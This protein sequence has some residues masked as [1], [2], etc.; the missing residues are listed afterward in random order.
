M[1]ETLDT[2]KAKSSTSNAYDKLT[3]QINMSFQEVFEKSVI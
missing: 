1:E 3:K 2:L